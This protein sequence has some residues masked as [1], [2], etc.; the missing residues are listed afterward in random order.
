M[1]WNMMLVM[2]YAPSI[3]SSYVGMNKLDAALMMQ[4]KRCKSCSLVHATVR[5]AVC[6]SPGE[7]TAAS[8]P[9]CRR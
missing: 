5:R 8:Y 1:L 7:L 2:P 6:Y 3:R 4:R 9:P